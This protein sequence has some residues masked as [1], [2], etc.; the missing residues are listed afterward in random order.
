MHLDIEHDI[1]FKY[2]DFISESWVELRM[3]PLS[4]NRQTVNLFYLAVGPST[5]VCQ[6]KDWLGNS[7]R[8][9]SIAEYHKEIEVKA[10]TIV[11]TNPIE[12][13]LE[14]IHEPIRPPNTLG[15]LKD[16]LA[17]DGPITESNLLT[18]LH[19]SVPIT[20]DRPLGEQVKA[21]GNRVH[22]AIKYKANVT[23]YN[24][25]IDEALKKKAGVCQDMA[26]IMIGLLRLNGIP[27]RYVNGYLHVP[28]LKKATAESHA[29][30]EFHSEEFGWIG[31][32]PTGNILPHE[33]HVTVAV[34]RNYDEVPPNR[35]VY[36]GAAN[37][38]LGAT[39]KTVEVEAPEFS[40][41]RE[42]VQEIPLPVYRELPNRRTAGMPEDQIDQQSQQQQQQ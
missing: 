9:F 41:Y 24:S 36:R 14:S 29:W 22:E 32:D 35:G 26:Q 39:V 21:I 34:G 19:K 13:F 38:S 33:H 4:N 16:F 2:D 28:S 20:S 3:E 8:H 5:K 25:T 37:E 18:E 7:V 10:R 42:E 12:T 1:K 15:A 17:F 40:T 6:Y 30:I 23:T 31:Y 27:A 11:Q